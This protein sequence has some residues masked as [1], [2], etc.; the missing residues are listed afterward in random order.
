MV[1]LNCKNCEHNPMGICEKCGKEIPLSYIM[2]RTGKYPK[3][4][5]LLKKRVSA[6]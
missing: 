1:K 4:C 3:W 2:G 5:P 6:K